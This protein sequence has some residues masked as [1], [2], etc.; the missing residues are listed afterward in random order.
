MAGHAR[1]WR[2]VEV[3][4]LHP[5]FDHLR[6][7]LANRH[8]FCAFI[9]ECLIKSGPEARPDTVRCTAVQLVLSRPGRHPLV[10]IEVE[11]VREVYPPADHST[12]LGYWQNLSTQL[13]FDHGSPVQH[14]AYK[15]GLVSLTRQ[16]YGKNRCC[17][18]FF[19]TPCTVAMNGGQSIARQVGRGLSKQPSPRGR[20]SPCNKD[21][22]CYRT[23]IGHSGPS[24]QRTHNRAGDVSCA[25][26]NW[27]ASWKVLKGEGSELSE[28]SEVS[29]VVDS[30][31]IVV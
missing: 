28:S 24:I 9:L 21:L 22:S 23:H 30:K 12:R 8:H 6:A 2:K 4:A 27:P 17:R 31:A 10:S 26:H 7:A 16:D 19:G 15:Q 13:H 14:N 5:F 18:T 11:P 1:A 29:V 25:D 20:E 3:S